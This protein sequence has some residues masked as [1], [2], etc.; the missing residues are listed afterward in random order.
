SFLTNVVV[1]DGGEVVDGEVVHCGLSLD[2]VSLSAI[3]ISNL[4]RNSVGSLIDCLRTKA[5]ACG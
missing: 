5:G 1:V 4:Y 2:T 3:S